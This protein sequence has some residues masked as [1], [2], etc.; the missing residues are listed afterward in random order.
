M[1]H[2][3]SPITSIT[4]E[5]MFTCVHGNYIYLY[6]MLCYS[7]WCYNYYASIAHSG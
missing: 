7:Y 5:N 6:I 3:I 1:I 2:Y 4:S